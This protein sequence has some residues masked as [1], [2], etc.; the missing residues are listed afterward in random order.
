[1]KK[2]ILKLLLAFLILFVTS[3]DSDDKIPN[4]ITI[5]IDQIKAFNASISWETNMG[6]NTLYRIVLNNEVKAEA[7]AENNFTFS[8]LEEETQYEGAVYATSPDGQSTFDTFSFTTTKNT[9]GGYE[10]ITDQFGVDNFPYTAIAKLTIEG[11]DIVNLSNLASLNFVREEIVVQ[12]TSL[13]T[14]D[15]LENILSN[16][17]TVIRIENNP[18]LKDISAIRKYFGLATR[19]E[20]LNNPILENLEGLEPQKEIKALKLTNLGIKNLSNFSGVTKID[21]LY[22]EKLDNITDTHLSV[23][24]QLTSTNSLSLRRMNQ[25]VELK[26]FDNLKSTGNLQI[27]GNSELISL[28]GISNLNNSENEFN[29]SRVTITDNEKLLD[30]C[31]IREYMNNVVIDVI[32]EINYR[33]Y[34]VENNLY[35]PTEEDIKGVK[36]KFNTPPGSPVNLRYDLDFTN[37][38]LEW[39]KPN[40]VEGDNISY[41]LYIGKWVLTYTTNDIF[42][43]LYI[44]FNTPLTE[45][46]DNF[47]SLE[48]LDPLSY[49]RIAVTTVDNFGNESEPM[50]IGF[51][52]VPSGTYN[53]DIVLTD[54]V[55]VDL[56]KEHELEILNGNLIIGGVGPSG[57]LGFEVES[58]TDLTPLNG[59]REINGSLI[60]GSEV[61]GSDNYNLNF[62]ELGEG[63]KNLLKI[64]ENLRIDNTNLTSLNG[65]DTLTHIGETIS[66][67]DTP[68]LDYCALSDFFL[69]NTFEISGNSYNP[70]LTDFQDGNCSN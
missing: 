4:S 63:F 45:I 3:C 25:L 23:F 5:K 57:T 1:M 9:V 14:L 34:V 18:K 59:I 35:N 60:F 15:G 58:I 22:L 46:S 68:I 51:S 49:Y 10:R 26:G 52:T 41:K 8:D 13:E 2:T 54:Q 27:I 7:L 67:K 30:F 48:N 40:G 37:I 20:L 47:Y 61:M 16:Q 64:Q 53:G 32:P 21:E 42:T 50:T 39:E 55:F 44:D 31:G 11:E 17:N 70:T 29:I 38:R 12:N 56:F 19:V 36:C 43:D 69:T 24:S 62:D 65:F 66:I 33:G 6:S 28:E